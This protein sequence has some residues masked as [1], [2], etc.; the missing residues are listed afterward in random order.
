M[1]PT[2][3][4]ARCR[5]VSDVHRALRLLILVGFAA[6]ALTYIVVVPPWEATDEAGHFAYVKYL[7]DNRVLPYQPPEPGQLVLSHWF[8]PPLYYAIGALVT[9]PIDVSDFD[10]VAKPNPHFEWV[11]GHAPGGWNVFVPTEWEGLLPGGAVLAAYLLRLVN[12]LMGLGTV[13]LTYRLARR[14]LPSQPAVALAASAIVAFNPA[15]VYMGAG[16]HNDNLATLLGAAILVWSA[17]LVTATAD[18]PP[19]WL[20]GVLL[21]LALLAKTSAL[22]FGPVVAAAAFLA[23][24][25]IDG[26]FDRRALVRGGRAAGLVLGLAGLVAGWWY[27]RN[28]IIYGDP[29]AWWRY[30]TTH[31]FIV[32]QGRF[33]LDALGLAASQLGRTFWAAFGYMNLVVDSWI[34]I[35]LWIA[36]A[37]AGGGLLLAPAV[38]WIRLDLRVNAVGWALVVGALLLYL[39]SLARYSAALIGVGHGRLIFPVLPVAALLLALGLR[40][41]APWPLSRVTL[42]AVPLALAGLVALCPFVYIR[43][44][45]ALPRPLASVPATANQAALRFGDQLAV[46]GWQVEPAEVAPG[47]SATL[48][49]VWQAVAERPA[50]LLIDVR[51]RD[52]EGAELFRS[53]R[54][55]LEARLPSDRWRAGDTYAD[56]YQLAV[57]ARA[58]A[59]LSSIEVGV[60][61]PRGGY[62]AGTDAGGRRHEPLAPLGQLAV[63][64]PTSQGVPSEAG[65]AVEAAFAGGIQLRSAALEQATVARGGQLALT[66]VWSTDQPIAENYAVFVHV[67]GADGRPVAQADGEPVDGGAPTSVWKIGELVN[68]RRV[69]TIPSDAASGRYR[70]LVGLYLN[71]TGA[72]LPVVGGGGRERDFVEVGTV[73]VGA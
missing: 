59:G 15:F 67:A 35:A 9:T 27:L 31:G 14:L 34:Y 11:Q 65:K 10:E 6:A 13:L 7:R 29:I 53:E 20:G 60:R 39:G 61:A 8:H 69:M 68:D 70:L 2:T 41:L 46:V 37:A 24:R 66:L 64:R 30:M 3:S 51:L 48:T 4:S 25:P 36:S 73:T 40:G 72:R 52:R 44:A 1:G 12:L 23:A 55:P 47:E 38:R 19:L 43:P 58:Y 54:R 16:A 62:L 42:A 17:E 22:A 45:Y 5:V 21:G 63:R 18:R 26:S 71:R 49:L 50:D 33:D 32:R 56:R 28:L 57:P